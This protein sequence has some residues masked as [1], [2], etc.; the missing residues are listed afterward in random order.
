MYFFISDFK[1]I[2]CSP[3]CFS[4]STLK[5]QSIEADI[6]SPLRTDYLSYRVQTRVRSGLCR[7]K[8][9][10]FIYLFLFFEPLYVLCVYFSYSTFKIQSI[11]ALFPSPF[12]TD[13]LSYRVQTRVRSGLCRIKL[14]YAFLYF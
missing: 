1:T 12:P 9:T 11:E 7:I 6:P 8:M 2:S 14:K 3:M 10:Y 13:H 5:M 4:C